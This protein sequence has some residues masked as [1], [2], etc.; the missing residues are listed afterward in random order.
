A[1]AAHGGRWVAAASVP[2]AQ[3]TLREDLRTRLA[4]GLVF[5]VRALADSD[6]AH[7]LAVYAN[8]R[9]FRL[10]T[11]VIDYLLAH[12]RRDMGSLVATLAAL[13][14]RSLAT[15]RGVTIPLVRDWLRR[16]SG[17]DETAG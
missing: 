6:K 10:S 7:A 14:R 2:P 8:E 11:D 9:G 5:E 17:S 15:R 12:A 16:S 3:M 4:L 13:D 1:L